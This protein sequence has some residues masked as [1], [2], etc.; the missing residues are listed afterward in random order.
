MDPPCGHAEAIAHR[1]VPV[2]FASDQQALATIRCHLACAPIFGV[3]K[4]KHS[5]L[6]PKGKPEFHAE[7]LR[8]EPCD[9]TTT[10]LGNPGV[11]CQL[12]PG[13]GEHEIRGLLPHSL[14]RRL[15]KWLRVISRS[16]FRAGHALV[17][18]VS[19]AHT[20]GTL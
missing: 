5:C 7:W 18:L 6:P 13:D 2:H 8:D 12:L 19:L 10:C 17:F 1:T 15:R 16:L 14:R 20:R 9:A 3:V 4:T 11:W